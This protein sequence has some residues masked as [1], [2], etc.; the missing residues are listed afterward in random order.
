M[1]V[2]GNGFSPISSQAIIWTNIDLCHVDVWKH[3][4]T[5]CNEICIKIWSFSFNKCIQKLHNNSHFVQDSISWYYS[6]ERV[7]Q[8]ILGEPCW[9]NGYWCLGSFCL[10]VISNHGIKL[11]MIN[12]LRLEGFQLSVLRHGRNSK[13]IFM[14]PEICSA[15]QVLTHYGLVMPCGVIKL[16]QHWFS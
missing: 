12:T 10:Q 3:I 16:G 2:S 14:F 5:I 1:I 8:N 7:K 15:P 9:F 6:T 11:C 4:G 13:Y